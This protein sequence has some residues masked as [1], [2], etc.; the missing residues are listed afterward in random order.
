MKGYILKTDGTVVETDSHLH[1]KGGSLQTLYTA[2][3]CT[4]VEIV[5]LKQ[6]EIWCDE[7]GLL[8]R[9][10][11]NPL[12]SAIFQAS[13][14]WNGQMLVGDVYVRLRKG[15]KLGSEGVVKDA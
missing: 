3:G 12:A 4:L 14:P 7:E 10:P 1:E 11:V 9:K 6:G 13:N 15:Y 8:N 2:L 5:R